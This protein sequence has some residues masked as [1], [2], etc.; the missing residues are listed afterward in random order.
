MS[1]KESILQS[2]LCLFAKKGFKDTSMSDLSKMTGAAE[3]TIFY[4]FKN[5]ETLFI[6]I[7]EMVKSKIINEFDRYTAKKTF[8]TGLEMVEEVISFYLYMAGHMPDFFM[9][10][11]RHDAYELAEVNPVCREYLEDTYNCLVDIFEKAI[12]L[13]K[14]DGSVGDIP[15][16]KNALL[17]FT[18]TDGLV[19]FNSYNLYDAGA[20]YSELIAS[21]RRMLGTVAS[22][23]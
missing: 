4:H 18:L 20:L 13:G 14:E 3:G 6:T 12:N 11:H 16:R 9:L 7:L 23:Q 8:R 10:L 21:C 1:K 2:A 5:K 22:G 17:I 15:A 19:R